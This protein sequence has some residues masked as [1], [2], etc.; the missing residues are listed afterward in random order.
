ALMLLASDAFIQANSAQVIQ[1]WP[2]VMDLN[3]PRINRT[4][5]VYPI[6]MSNWFHR[7]S[8]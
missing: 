4:Q 6:T 7:T 2:T 8:A 3:P 5:L 1:L